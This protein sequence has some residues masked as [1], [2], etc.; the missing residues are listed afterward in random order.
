MRVFPDNLSG[1]TRT[2]ICLRQIFLDFFASVA[3]ERI[4]GKPEAGLK[5]R[6]RA[7]IAGRGEEWDAR[8]LAITG[9]VKA[10]TDDR[11]RS[12]GQNPRVRRGGRELLL[13]RQQGPDALHEVER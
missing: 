9:E 5:K 8:W 3:C 10:T 13:G 12:E 1:N 6:K 7:W 11:E 4:L 2:Q